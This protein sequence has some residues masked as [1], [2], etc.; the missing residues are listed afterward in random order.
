M[1]TTK[2]ENVTEEEFH[3]K[4]KRQK[5]SFDTNASFDGCMFET[6]GEELEYVFE[7]SKTNRVVTIIEGDKD[8]E[9]IFISDKGVEITEPLSNLYY[10]SGFHLVNRFGYFVLYKPYEYEFE[11]KVD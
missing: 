11:V 4:F 1:E 5:N 2:I 9:R 6:Y 8:G 10:V 3:K 7:M